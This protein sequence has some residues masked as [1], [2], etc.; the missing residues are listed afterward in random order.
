MAASFQ[1]SDLVLLSDFDGT[2][3]NFSSKI[4]QRNIDALHRFVEKGGHF[5]LAT[6]RPTAHV[7]ELAAHLPI[8][9]P[10]ITFNGACIYDLK[11]QRELFTHGISASVKGYLQQLIQEH[12]HLGVIVMTLDTLYNVG[13]KETALEYCQLSAERSVP[14]PESG[15]PDNPFKV[16]LAGSPE[17]IDEIERQL[18]GNEPEGAEFIR[19]DAH[20]YDM[21]PAGQSKG[22]AMQHLLKLIGADIR[23]TL[24]IGDYYNDIHMLELAGIGAATAEAPDLVKV[25]ANLVVGSCEGGAV[26][27]FIE[28]IEHMYG[29]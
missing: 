24:A 2:M 21:I 20:F 16:L 26:A 19:T 11:A 18:A 13:N 22:T 1:I 7:R 5:T 12:P 17:E 29:L 6:G 27:D 10:A 25:S 14:L 23:H 28:H 4:P 9:L 3:T 15:L 8:N